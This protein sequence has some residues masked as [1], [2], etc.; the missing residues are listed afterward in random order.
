[1]PLTINNE[2]HMY[3]A[4]Y[5]KRILLILSVASIALFTPSCKKNN[6]DD[7][8]NKVDPPVQQA[9]SFKNPLI[10]GAD[11]FVA[12][13]DGYYYF[14]STRGGDI[15]IAKTRAMSQLA[16]AANKVVW[17]PAQNTEY[18]A[19]IWAPELHFLA[20]KWYIYFAASQSG[21]DNSN[22]MFVLENGNADPTQ[23]TWTF[24][25]KIFDATN[26]Q[27]AVDG[28]ILTIGDKNYLIWSGWE[29][30]SERFKQLIYIA[31]MSNPWTLSG[32]RVTISSPTN[33]WEKYEPSSMGIGVNEGPIALQR[34]ANSPMFVIFSASRYTSDNYC[35]AQIQLKTSGNP[36]IA[37]DWIN[38][39]QVF[40]RND[41]AA[42]YGPGH[43]G[44]FTSSK[45]DDKGVIQTENWFIY[46]ARSV[47][48]QP[49]GA[50]T[51][52][53]QKL[54]WNTDGSPN[55]GSAIGTNVDIPKPIG[56]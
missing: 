45:T 34:D 41:N 27:W 29:S 11:P 55:F 46:H 39:K 56:E 12:Q 28:S 26:D 44:F 17:T 1:M 47:P 21:V 6:T 10:D 43:N 8:I 22:R 42:V 3:F 24:K 19:D 14:L 35:L 7:T 13:K 48:N 5:M 18:S 38:K 32:P 53:M 4:I 2:T 20:G 30:V 9:K 37:A 52:R 40:V 25:G 23:G 31:P 33:V 15:A 36:L 16:T 49:N 54:T 51:S 50:R